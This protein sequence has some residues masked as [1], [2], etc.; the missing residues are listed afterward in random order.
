[1]N[2]LLNF[3]WPLLV[4]IGSLFVL[5]LDVGSGLGSPGIWL[6]PAG[7][8]GMIITSARNGNLKR[9]RLLAIVWLLA[10]FSI[11]AMRFSWFD[12]EGYETFIYIL[13]AEIFTLTAIVLMLLEA[14]KS[15]KRSNP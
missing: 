10:L 1:M 5:V 8:L 6:I 4:I 11:L 9:L 14:A 13:P 15:F 7:V 12:T 2:I 3:L